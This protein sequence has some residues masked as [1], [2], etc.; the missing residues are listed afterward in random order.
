MRKL[1]LLII[2]AG[3]ILKLSSGFSWP[4]KKV[5]FITSAHN[6]PASAKPTQAQLSVPKVVRKDGY[7]INLFAAYSIDALVL[8]V[9]NYRLGRESDLSPIDL[10]LGWGPMSLPSNLR[11]I[12]VTQGFRWYNYTYTDQSVLGGG[13]IAENSA[14]THII[15]ADAVVEKALKKVA[16]GARVQMTGYLADV[17]ASDGWNWN[18]SRSRN[19]EGQG[20]CELFYV[21]EIRVI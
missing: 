14:N 17:T 10:A 8:S 1:F 6:L 20:S 7:K 16:P 13:I 4:E 12:K 18:S 9:E 3:I 11:G 5:K 2:L 19:D 21:T 15:P